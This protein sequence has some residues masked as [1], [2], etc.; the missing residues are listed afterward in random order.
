[1]MVAWTNAQ[2]TTFFTNAAHMGLSDETRAALVVKGIDAPD[3]LADF[4]AARS[5]LS[6]TTS[7]V[8]QEGH[9]TL[10][11]LKPPP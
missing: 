9:H 5:S 7:A 8:H 11:L 2:R 1:M 6:R 3:D 4:E 10:I